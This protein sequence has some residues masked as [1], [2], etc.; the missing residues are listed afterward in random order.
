MT[1]TVRVRNILGRKGNAQYTNSI[2]FDDEVEHYHEPLGALRNLV[3]S[4][5]RRHRGYIYERTTSNKSRLIDWPPNQD[6]S[7][8]R[9]ASKKGTSPRPL[10]FSLDR[11]PKI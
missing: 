4:Q 8:G 5:I 3:L 7:F 1:N 2:S 10:L 9:L 6:R 11:R